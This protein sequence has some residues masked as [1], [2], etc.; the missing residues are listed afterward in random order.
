MKQLGL[1]SSET[2]ILYGTMPFVGFFVRPII[3]AMADHWHK[4]KLMLMVCSV[5]TG[6]FYLLILTIPR[7]VHHTLMVHTQL[8]CNVQDSF[9]RDCVSASDRNADHSTCNLQLSEF[10]DF[11]LNMTNGNGMDLDCEV[12]CTDS[13][14]S[15][16]QEVA[17]C[18]TD[19]TEE[20]VKHCNGTLVTK[21]PFAFTLLN[22]S[23]ML[24][25][26]VM[27]DRIAEASLQCRDYDLKSLQHNS[28]RHWQLLCDEE[29][30]FQCEMT[31]KH[32]PPQFCPNP[33][34]RFDS[35]FG[36][37]FLIYLIANLAFAPVFSLSDAITFDTLGKK[38]HKFG[39]QRLW[40]TVGFAAS[41]ITSTFIMY[42]MTKQ[43]SSFN[44]TVPFYIFAILCCLAAAIAH[45]M[46]LSSNIKCGKMFENFLA[47]KRV[48]Q[49][50]VFLAVVLFFG[51]ATGA[52]EGFL[53]WYLANLGA[54]TLVFGLSLVVN[55]LFEVSL[56]CCCCCGC[57]C[58]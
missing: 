34:H 21:T 41:A 28:Q 29:G 6:L 43:G 7:R 12:H 27:Q 35:T 22:I 57:C 31:C 25:S 30:T 19:D 49:V 4:H 55:C 33:D 36:W 44:L 53:F 39:E 5:L 56:C 32:P 37:L 58:C 40:G 11:M 26:E 46:S 15:A 18:F 17:L 2:G 24:N 20:F 52:V 38:H 48:P 42:M 9:F 3:G 47:L 1:S 14:D 10:A 8:D 16:N 45:L 51:M 54:T 23:H 13:P 50:L